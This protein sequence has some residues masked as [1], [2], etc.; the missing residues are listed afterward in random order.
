MVTLTLRR[1]AEGNIVAF[2]LTGHAGFGEYPHDPVCAGASAIAQTAIGSLQDI[3]GL[4]DVAY[5]LERGLISCELPQEMTEKQEQIAQVLMEALRIGCL[6]ISFSYG[7]RYLSVKD[8][9]NNGGA[10]A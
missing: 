8:S 9:E 4:T 5:T 3:A 10:Q 1:D 2:T 6:Q 7:K